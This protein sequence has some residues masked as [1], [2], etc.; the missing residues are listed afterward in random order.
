MALGVVTA[1]QLLLGLLVALSMI[2]IDQPAEGS[3]ALGASLAGVGLVFAGVAAVAAQV[4]ETS[5]SMYGITGAALGAAYLLRAAGDV[6][7]GTLSWLSPIGWGQYMR[8]YAGE[9]WW[10]LALMVAPVPR[11]SPARSRCAR[12]ATRAP[13]IL[14]Q[15]PGPPGASRC[16]STRWGSRC[17]SSAA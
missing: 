17:A 10:P 8:P 12:A 4:S 3:F 16:S 13:G 14:P 9:Q 11:S 7:D 5:S 1:V 15:R 6:G 2:A